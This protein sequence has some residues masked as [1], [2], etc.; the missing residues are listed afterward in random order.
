MRFIY[1]AFASV[2]LAVSFVW[3]TAVGLGNLVLLLCVACSIALVI[4]CCC[5]DN[6][7]GASS[8]DDSFD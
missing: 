8:S 1:R 2:V 4:C 6:K 3:L 5:E 7:E